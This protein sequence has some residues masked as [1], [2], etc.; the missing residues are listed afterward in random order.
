M[1]TARKKAKKR[2]DFL[3][4]KLSWLPETIFL[5]M[6][7]MSSKRSLILTS[8]AIRCLFLQPITSNWIYRYNI[9]TSVNILLNIRKLK[10]NS[11]SLKLDSRSIFDTLPEIATFP[12]IH[13]LHITKIRF[14]EYVTLQWANKITTLKFF[15]D[16]KSVYGCRF[17]VRKLP[18][19]L[20]SLSLL[21]HET[22][23][24]IK[25]GHEDWPS[26]LTQMEI[27][28]NIQRG[29]AWSCPPNLQILTVSSI[30]DSFPFEPIPTSLH[31]L[32][33][34]K[35]VTLCCDMMH[36]LPLTSLRHLQLRHF[37]MSGDTSVFE[38]LTHL[39]HL[40]CESYVLDIHSK[41]PSGLVPLYI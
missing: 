41:Y 40:K 30:A 22:A 32:I 24:V 1:Q 34:T 35:E 15:F 21:T 29:F 31:T 33:C 2:S 11:N 12:N 4:A 17:D 36:L 8:K 37:D 28:G 19:S 23:K 26:H 7:N 10:I 38:K 27:C 6:L 14:A 39:T 13:T 9:Q 16:I 18:P 20:T 5:P 3:Q 25:I